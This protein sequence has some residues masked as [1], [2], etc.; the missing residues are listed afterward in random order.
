MTKKLPEFIKQ[1][2]KARKQALKLV[3]ELLK[4][5]SKAVSITIENFTEPSLK[6]FV[7]SSTRIYDDGSRRIT[8]EWREK[9]RLYK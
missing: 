4:D 3:E 7:P 9:P 2:N 1:Q 6:A 8:L 5:K